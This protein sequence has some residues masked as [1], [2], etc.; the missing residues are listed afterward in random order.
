V[1]KAQATTLGH[2]KSRAIADPAHLK[3]FFYFEVLG[4][5]LL[6]LPDLCSGIC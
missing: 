1:L 4:F 5:S 3:I 6:S 2:K